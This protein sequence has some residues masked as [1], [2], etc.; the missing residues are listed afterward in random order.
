[1]VPGLTFSRSNC[2]SNFE[3]R[4]IKRF[5][6]KYFENLSLIVINFCQSYITFILW[7]IPE[8]PRPLVYVDSQSTLLCRLLCQL[9]HPF[10]PLGWAANSP[11]LPTHGGQVAQRFKCGTYRLHV[12]YTNSMIIYGYVGIYQSSFSAAIAAP[13]PTTV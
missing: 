9:L 4:N 6:F 5:T 1:M 3:F 12:I 11:M 8:V 10:H 2:N 7:P 13:D